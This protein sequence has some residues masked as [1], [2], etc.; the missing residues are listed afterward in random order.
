[1]LILSLLMACFDD[2]PAPEVAPA[3]ITTAEPPAPLSFTMKSIKKDSGCTTDCAAFEASWPVFTGGGS[4]SINAW[5]QQGVSTSGMTGEPLASPEA[6]AEAFISDWTSYRAED[7]EAMGWEM[8]RSVNVVFESSDLVV[9]SAAESSYTGGAHGNYHSTYATFV[10]QTGRQLA[11]SDILVDGF[12]EK[13]RPHIVAGLEADMQTPIAEA[14]LDHTAEDVPLAG[15]W[16]VNGEAL[17]FHYDPY[18]IGPY[19]M[20]GPSA[21]IPRGKIAALIRKDSLW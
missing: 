11:L 16:E 18:E 20:G 10:R 6:T 4:S 17:V 7:P 3:V 19:V 15:D 13:L 12:E 21:V 8:S 1:M 9:I 14:G 5:V 2:T